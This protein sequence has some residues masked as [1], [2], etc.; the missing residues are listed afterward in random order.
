MI[1]LNRMKNNKIIKNSVIVVFFTI[2]LSVFHSCEIQ[3]DFKYKNTDSSGVLGI[4]VWDYMTQQDSFTLLKKAIQLTG[5]QNF[6]TDNLDRTYIVP[7]NAAFLE[8]LET[9]SYAKLEDVPL[10]ILRNALK[11]HIVNSKVLFTDPDLIERNNPL[12]YKT[13]NGQIMYLSHNSNFIGLIN[14][15]TS[16]QWGIVTS[17]LEPINGVIHVVSS[18][19]YFSAPSGD[20]SIPDPSIIKD[21]IFPIYDT[22]INGGS[23]SAVNFGSANLMKVKNVTGNGNYDRKAYLMYDLKD[24][25]KE[26]IITDMKFELGVK[27][28]HAKGVSLDLYNVKD[29]LWSEM[30]LT[31]N[32]ATFPENEPIA[33]ITTTKINTFEFNITDFFNNLDYTGRVSFMLDG[34]AGTNETDEFYSK[35]TT[36]GNNFPMLI[37][38]L[39]SG[40]NVLE[41]N[42]NSGFTVEKGGAFAFNK[43]VLE[44][45]GAA[46]EDIIFTVEEV[47]QYGWLVKGANIL[48]VGDKFTQQDVDVMNLLYINNGSGATED[49]IVI[50]AKDRAGSS[51]EAFDVEITIQ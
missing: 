15:G 14:E 18:I 45:I 31:F 10:P 50:S 16:K 46:P 35:E 43:D 7:T 33:S 27:F 6:Y 22:Y 23:K 5:L 29:T 9:N 32:N 4:S 11:Y 41:F 3:E 37:A 13:E 26:G 12:P 24:F 51:L 1:K 21:T 48:K 47:P 34:E 28:T 49:K 17:N 19:V 8:Y 42:T 20:L 38:T 44:I 25:K 40:N 30:G 2:I 39:A 36:T